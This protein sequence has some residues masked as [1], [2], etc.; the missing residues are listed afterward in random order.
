M[1]TAPTIALYRPRRPRET[2]LYRLIER[3]F[4]QF[5]RIYPDRYEKRYGYRPLG[6]RRRKIGHCRPACRFP[7]YVGHA[8]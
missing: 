7:V 5:E 6:D 1:A 8:D 4:P 2:P 3:F